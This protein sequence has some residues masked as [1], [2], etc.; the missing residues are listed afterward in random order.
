MKI[1]RR[2]TEYIQRVETKD[3]HVTSTG[4][5]QKRRKI[6]SRSRRIRICNKRSSFTRTKR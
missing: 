2:K 5:T 3:N 1:D 6:E 4:P